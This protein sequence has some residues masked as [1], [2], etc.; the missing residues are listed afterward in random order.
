MEVNILAVKNSS[1]ERE[2]P[3]GHQWGTVLSHIYLQYI[4]CAHIF[5]RPV[6]HSYIV[7]NAIHFYNWKL[8][9]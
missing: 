8:L 1:V 4:I 3:L 9:C 5:S 2:V 6:I 7:S